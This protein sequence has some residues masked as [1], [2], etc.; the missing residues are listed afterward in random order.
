MGIRARVI[1]DTSRAAV[2]DAINPRVR[3]TD[4][5]ASLAAVLGRLTTAMTSA[6]VQVDGLDDVADSERLVTRAGVPC[7]R[8]GDALVIVHRLPPFGEPPWRAA[9]PWIYNALTRALSNHAAP[10]TN[11]LWNGRALPLSTRA[12]VMGVVN[13]TP[14]SF[15]DG[16]RFYDHDAAIDQ[17]LQL[18]HEGADILDIGGESTRPGADPVSAEEEIRRVVPVIEA[19]ASKIDIPI[20]VDTMKAGVARAALDAGAQIVND[21]SAGRFD[22]D[23]LRVT[24][25]AGVPYVA[26]HM[27][28]EPR[29]MQKDPTYRDVVGEVYAFLAE[30][31]EAAVAAGI[32][33]NRIIVDPGFGF[34]KS[35]EHNLVLLRRLRELT[36]L[37]FPVLAGTSRKTFIGL[38]LDLPVE[39]RL[40][41]T[42]ATVATAVWNGAAIVRVHD[43]APM[44]RVASMVEAVS[45]ANDPGLPS[46]AGEA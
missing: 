32:S 16:G 42:A 46:G 15:S 21:V 38:T 18:V 1:A 27:R 6:V 12:H 45:R 25:D 29:T 14:D 43:V 13:I 2:L 37:G 26:M 44:R 35:R 4:D 8:F 24:G 17:G 5:T 19:L 7:A 33:E 11:I 20:S 22:P 9:V 10:P 3:D 36:C 31:A 40:E 28:G 34:G 39:E 41:G 30:R 23:I